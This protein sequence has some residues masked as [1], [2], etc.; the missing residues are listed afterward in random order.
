MNKKL[1]IKPI[2]TVTIGSPSA[3]TATT[4]SILDVLASVGRDW[5]ILHGVSP[6][7]VIVFEPSLR[8]MTGAPYW[9]INGRRVTPDAA[10]SEGPAPDLVIV[11]DMH[12]A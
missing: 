10:L 9:D 6:R 2:R 8:T 3:G 4:F 7:E 11:P 1:S 5:E 12:L